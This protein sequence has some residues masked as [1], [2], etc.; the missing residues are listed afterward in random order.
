MKNNNGSSLFSLRAAFSSL[1]SLTPGMNAAPDSSRAHPPS[2]V[3]PQS[4]SGFTKRRQSSRIS[5][6]RIWIGRSGLRRPVWVTG[7]QHYRNLQFFWPGDRII[8]VTTTHEACHRGRN[9]DVWHSLHV[10][11]HMAQARAGS[12]GT[13]AQGVQRVDLTSY[14]GSRTTLLI[15]HI[16]QVAAPA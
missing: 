4:L 7:L 11:G 1:F 14:D 16:M 13:A 15:W 10:H 2:R 3:F 8:V 9:G 6:F 5:I 12:H